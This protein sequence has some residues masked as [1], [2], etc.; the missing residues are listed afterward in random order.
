MGVG[1]DNIDRNELQVN[2][3][4]ESKKR[5]SEGRFCMCPKKG[6][7]TVGAEDELANHEAV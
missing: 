1:S 2:L 7:I 5:I 4:N 6:K 3:P